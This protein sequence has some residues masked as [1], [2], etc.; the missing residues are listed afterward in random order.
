MQCDGYEVANQPQPMAKRKA[1]PCSAGG[2]RR[3]H[4]ARGQLI[5]LLPLITTHIFK[6]KMEKLLFHHVQ[7]CTVKDLATASGSESFWYS[8]A[9]PLGYSV[10]P[11][12]HALCAL[13]AAHRSFLSRD[14]HHSHSSLPH[15]DPGKL[16]IR[17]YN[18][19]ILHIQALMST[20]SATNIQI[21]LVCCIIFI[22]VES[23]Q[24][25]YPES[26]QHLRAGWRLLESFPPVQN[27]PTLV[28][29]G[30][31]RQD[32]HFFRDVTGMLSRLNQDSTIYT[33]DDLVPNPG[34]FL[35]SAVD[36]GDPRMP[37]SSSVEAE[38]LLHDIDLLYESA[39]DS[40][41]QGCGLSDDGFYN[42]EDYDS[43]IMESFHVFGENK[44]TCEDIINLFWN[45]SARFDLFFG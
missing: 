3:Q 23:I 24:G 15:E 2:R 1:P 44:L 8:Y 17:H 19:A 28:W 42:E 41:Y 32:T 9:L 34:C 14:F 22:C 35:L 6:L 26:L 25:R 29:L 37:F 20:P 43:Q 39:M 38:K 4:L 5:P 27:T 45:W 40:P 31:H 33:G 10:D 18:A 16:A 7:E 13:G 36:I 30:E 11:I 21:I 12:K